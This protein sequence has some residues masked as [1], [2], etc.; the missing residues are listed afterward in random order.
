MTK[1]VIVRAIVL[2]LLI[3]LSSCFSQKKVEYLRI[4]NSNK[5]GFTEADFPD[6]KLKSNDELFVQI[7]SLDEA[8]TNLFSNA[9]NQQSSSST[10]SPYGASLLS[11]SVDKEGYVFFPVIGNV[12]VK[13]KTLSQ[14]IEILKDSLIHVLNQPIIT[15]KLVNRYVSVLGEV[16][17]PGHYPYSQ[18]KLSIYN[19][20]GLAGDITD[21]G[22]PGKVVLVRNENG[23]NTQ[24]KLDLTDPEILG[25]KYYYLR[26]NDLI[27]VKPLHSKVWRVRQ[28]PL[29]LFFSAVTTGL[30]IYNIFK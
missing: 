6:Y 1:Q 7:N 28:I 18:E 22:N 26:P 17:N 13:G 14:V 29:T 23:E 10:M 3:F 11:Y 16:R 30:L 2:I 5:R 12:L 25:S 24:V 9:T 8:T 15:L 20:L 21:Y 4:E 27:Y 19:A